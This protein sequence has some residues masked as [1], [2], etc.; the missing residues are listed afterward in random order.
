MGKV[1]EFEYKM[2]HGLNSLMYLCSPAEKKNN[3]LIIY[4]H[5]HHSNMVSFDFGERTI[6]FFLSKGYHV[7]SMSMPL[8]WPNNRK[9]I[10]DKEHPLSANLDGVQ[11]GADSAAHNSLGKLETSKLC[12]V[13]FLIESVHA[14]LNLLACSGY[15]EEDGPPLC[16]PLWTTEYLKAIAYPEACLQN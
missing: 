11:H 4:H 8:T 12:P 10:I 3:K 9:M 1:R 16:A 15:L 14:A 5:G 6:G 13:K 7:M 2:S